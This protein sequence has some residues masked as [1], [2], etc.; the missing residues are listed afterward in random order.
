MCI[1]CSNNLESR[2]TSHAAS[3]RQ[4]LKNEDAA[5]ESDHSEALKRFLEITQEVPSGLPQ[6]DG[7]ARV[8][9]ASKRVH[10]TSERYRIAHQRWTDF[11]LKGIVPDDADPD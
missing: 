2:K 10:F 4:R 11:L 1:A 7:A 9:Q 8:T 3:V 5:A 6:P